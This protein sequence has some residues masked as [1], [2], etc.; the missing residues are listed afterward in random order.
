MTTI[1]KKVKV[2]GEKADLI[3]EAVKI[4]RRMKKDEIRLAAIKK[5]LG[6]RAKAT[7]TTANGGILDISER[8]GKPV[9]PAAIALVEL[10][11]NRLGTH[12]SE[13]VSVVAKKLESVLGSEKT[14]IL[15]KKYA[16]NDTLSWSFK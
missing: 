8:A 4:K 5:S 11:K 16:G 3:N 10:K 9:I 1:K 13:C 14:N 7:Y 15:K 2:S 6:Y 12:F